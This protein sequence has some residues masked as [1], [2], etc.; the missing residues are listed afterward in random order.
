MRFTTKE[1]KQK[2]LQI[3]FSKGIEA[4]K[5]EM[6]ENCELPLFVDKNEPIKASGIE[7]TFD[8]V[9]RFAPEIEIY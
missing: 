4:A 8:E 6:I 9:R 1:A 7:F 5:R 3:S 2:F